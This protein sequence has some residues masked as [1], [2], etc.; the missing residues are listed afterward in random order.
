M[1]YHIWSIA[2]CCVLRNE[3]LYLKHERRVCC[4]QLFVLVDF[5]LGIVMSVSVGTLIEMCEVSAI[6]YINAGDLC[7]TIIGLSLSAGDYTGFKWG[8]RLY[9]KPYWGALI[10]TNTFRWGIITDYHPADVTFSGTVLGWWWRPCTLANKR[11]KGGTPNVR[12][13]SKDRV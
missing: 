13:W 6:V 4:S 9:T 11:L 12:G 3:C 2:T 10:Y 7:F 8:G 5:P 1:P